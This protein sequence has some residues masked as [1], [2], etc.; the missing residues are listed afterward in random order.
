[1]L[2]KTERAMKTLFLTI[3][4]TLTF[5]LHSA[6]IDLKGGNARPIAQ[7][8]INPNQVAPVN[9]DIPPPPPP[10]TPRERQALRLSTQAKDKD[11]NKEIDTTEP[12]GTFLNESPPLDP[13]YSK[14]PQAVIINWDSVEKLDP[15]ASYFVDKIKKADHLCLFPKNGVYTVFLPSNDAFKVMTKE[16][17]ESIFNDPEKTCMF[18]R[19]H[20]IYGSVSP[21][22]VFTTRAKTLNGTVVKLHHDGKNFMINDAKLVRENIV[23]PTNVSIHMIDKLLIP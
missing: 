10:P 22:K 16:M 19:Y 14:R 9:P 7:A 11:K 15:E 21:S 2:R 20:I 12:Q 4:L 3:L 1:M 6:G 18:L 23:A 13:L 17:E 8:Q 5:Q